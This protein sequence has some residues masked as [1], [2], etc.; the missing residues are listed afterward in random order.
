MFLGVLVGFDQQVDQTGHYSSVPQRGLVLL[1]QGQVADQADHGL[2]V[3][4]DHVM[5]P[6]TTTGKQLKGN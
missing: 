2:A 6:S 5:I 3:E 1:A 4:K